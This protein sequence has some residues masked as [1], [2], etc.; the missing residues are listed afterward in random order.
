M[1]ACAAEWD[2]LPAAQKS[3]YSTKGQGMKSKSGKPLSG[4]NAFSSE[5]LKK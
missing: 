3:A 1:K 5:C 4:Y 2:A